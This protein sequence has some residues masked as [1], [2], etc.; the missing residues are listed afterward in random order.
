MRRRAIRDA[1]GHMVADEKPGSALAHGHALTITQLEVVN[2]QL[3]AENAALRA[4]VAL[5]KWEA[6]A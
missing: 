3:G 1:N 6:A 2:Q 4:E 5:L